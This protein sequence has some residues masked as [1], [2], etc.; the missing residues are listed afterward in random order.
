MY[1]LGLFMFLGDELSTLACYNYIY[2]VFLHVRIS[3]MIGEK[4]ADIQHR[5][6]MYRVEGEIP[7]SHPT[8]SFTFTNHMF[9]SR[10]RRALSGSPLALIASVATNP[11]L[12]W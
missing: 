8:V 3:Q 7:I 5:G 6:K 4:I 2:R 11:V 12:I 9:L 1:E 10:G